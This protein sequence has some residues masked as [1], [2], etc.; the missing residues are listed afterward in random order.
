MTRRRLIPSVVSPA[1]D[2]LRAVLDR[3]TRTS[4]SGFVL[5]AL[6][7][8]AVPPGAL[9]NPQ[10]GT[11]VGGQAVISAPVPNQVLIQQQS[12]R[13]AIDWQSFSIGQG[14]ITRFQQPNAG[15][16]TLNRVTGG[17][18]SA[19]AG[20][21]EANGSI[22]LVNP[23]GIVFGQGAQV[24]VGGL[25]A[26][27]A[28]IPTS[29]FMAG[30]D[31]FSIPSPNPDAR[32]VNQ[33]T[34]NIRNQGLGALVAPGV[35]NQG[36]I[37]ARGG[38]IALGAAQTVTVDL[39]GDGLI[40]FDTGQPVQQAPLGP[41]GK[42][43][44]ALV[45]NS[46]TLSATGGT[47]IMSARAASDVVANV[48]NTTGVVEAL[49]VG[50]EG[51]AI[52]L[53]GGDTG[54]VRVDG[55]LDASGQDAGETGGSVTV[56][57]ERVVL[58]ADARVDASGQAGGGTA[59]IG[60]GWQGQGP[61]PTAQTTIVATGAQIDVSAKDRGDGGTAVVWADGNTRF[62]GTINARG[63]E[64]GGDGGQVEV[65]G[66]INLQF[67]GIVDAAAKRGRPGDL[68]LDPET[69]TVVEQVTGVDDGEVSDNLV[70]E[71]DSPGAN[72]QISANAIEA[73]AA[74]GTR[75]RLDA[76]GNITVDAVLDMVGGL[77]LTSSG[78]DITINQSVATDAFLDFSAEAGTITINASLSVG[79]ASS[80]NFA[81]LSAASFVL[82]DGVTVDSPNITVRGTQGDFVVGG[83]SG[84]L[85]TTALT[86]LVADSSLVLQA[87]D[88]T[89]VIGEAIAGDGS[90]FTGLFLNGLAGVTVDAA[91]TLTG[92]AATLSISSNG[93]I[94]VNAPLS[95]ASA[96]GN[97]SLTAGTFNGSNGDDPALLS[98]GG[99]LDAADIFLTAKSYSIT[100]DVNGETILLGQTGGDLI[101]GGADA[102]VTG[103]D[104][105]RLN[106]TTKLMIGGDFGAG[107]ITGN[108][109]I[110]DDLAFA[111]DALILASNDLVINA[112]ITSTSPGTAS[113]AYRLHLV[114]GND[115][116]LS[117]AG[118]VTGTYAVDPDGFFIAV[119]MFADGATNGEFD[120]EDGSGTLTID[121]L[122]ST[123]NAYLSLSAARYD[124][125][126][127]VDIATGVG[128]TV[129]KPDDVSTF[130]IGGADATISAADVMRFASATQVTFGSILASNGSDR[131]A[132]ETE[133]REA[134]TLTSATLIVAS[135]D[136][137]ID[138]GASFTATGVSVDESIATLRLGSANNTV[139]L[140][141]SGQLVNL[142][143]GG[144]V[145][146]SG[147]GNVSIDTAQDFSNL[148]GSGIDVQF[149]AGQSIFIN[150]AVDL[151]DG[152]YQF[153]A[154]APN[155]DVGGDGAGN[156]IL[157]APITRVGADGDL[158][159]S[160]ADYTV[161]A[162][163]DNAGGT[164]G[165]ANL[166]DPLTLG[167]LG[168][169]NAAELERF[170]TTGT[171][172]LGGIVFQDPAGDFLVAG[173]IVA[174][175]T[176]T[177]GTFAP[178][179]NAGAVDVV[180]NTNIVVD[181][182]EVVDF[183]NLTPGTLVR[184]LGV[185]TV[186]IGGTILA[187]NMDLVLHAD[188]G[189]TLVPGT[190]SVPGGLFVGGTV[191]AARVALAGYL[192]G[193]TGP[194]MASGE[195]S[196]VPS[197]DGATQE[198]YEPITD[199][200]LPPN[201]V[202]SP[203]SLQQLSGGVV[204]IGA[205]SLL[206]MVTGLLVVTEAL[207]LGNATLMTSL[208]DILVNADITDTGFVAPTGAYELE[209]RAG[210]NVTIAAG[211]TVTLDP[212]DNS[213]RN[214]GIFADADITGDGSTNNGAGAV[215]ILG[216]VLS[217][218][219]YVALS[220][221]GISV[222]TGGSVVGDTGIGIITSQP[223][224]AALVIG[225]SGNLLAADLARIGNG[226][227]TTTFGRIAPI[228]GTAT[229]NANVTINSS[230]AFAGP[231]V[232]AAAT[233]ITG[234]PGVNITADGNL[235]LD[236]PASFSGTAGIA[237]DGS[238][239]FTDTVAFLGTTTLSAGTTFAFQGAVTAT[240]QVVS[241]TA[242]GILSL[243]GSFGASQLTLESTGASVTVSGTVTVVTA[244]QVTAATT[245]SVAQVDSDNSVAF[246]T[247]GA[248]ALTGNVTAGSNLTI[249]GLTSG[250]AA[251]AV[252]Q[253]SGTT[254]TFGT[255]GDLSGGSVFINA[256]SLNFLG[257][258]ASSDELAASVN[259]TTSG[260]LTIAGGI[261]ASAITNAN[262][263]AGLVST[264]GSVN[265]GAVTLG[266]GALIGTGNGNVQVTGAISAA[267]G[268]D[269]TAAT[270]AVGVTGAL[271]AS[272]GA[273]TIQTAV[274]FNPAGT[275]TA[276]TNLSIASTSADLALFGLQAG[277]AIAITTN[278]AVQF[279]A[280][281]SAGQGI[282]VLGAGGSGAAASFSSIGTVTFG[283][284][285]DS[286]QS[287]V[288]ITANT[289]SISGGL[290]TADTEAFGITITALAGPALVGTIDASA[291]TRG[292][293]SV[294]V[295][296]TTTVDVGAINAG[297]GSITL[298]SPN[299]LTVSGRLD[300]G[301]S[302]TLTS[303]AAIALGGAVTAGGTGI[304]LTAGTGVTA[305]GNAALTTGAGDI[306]VDAGSGD[307]TLRAMTAD[308]NVTVRAD[309]T[310]ALGGS[311]AAGLSIA[312]GGS[313]TTVA[314]AVTQGAGIQAGFGTTGDGQ[315]STL[316]INA[317]SV[318]LD[319]TLAT[320]D[321]G[322][323]GITITTNPGA[324]AVG[325]IDAAA[326]TNTAFAVLL[327]ALGLTP[328]DIQVG[329]IAAG[330]GSVTLATSGAVDATGA[331]A[332][333][334]GIVIDAGTGITAAAGLTANSG[335]IDL[336]A[337][338]GAAQV[339]ALTAAG[340]VTI[341]ADGAIAL[342]GGVTAGQ[343]VALSGSSTTFSGAV[344]MASGL[345]LRFGTAN[346]T[347]VTA[348]SV[349][350]QSIALNG[351]ILTSDNQAGSIDLL[352][353]AGSVA[354]GSIAAGNAGPLLQITASAAGGSNS[355]SS[356]AISAGGGSVALS[357]PGLLTVGGSLLAGGDVTLTSSAAG[358]VAN[359]GITGGDITITAATGLDAL[360]GLDADAGDIAIDAGSGNAELGPVSASGGVQ[361]LAD[362]Q[363]RLND[364]LTAGLSVVLG[365]SSGG[366]AGAVIQAATATLQ[367]GTAGDATVSTLSVRGRSVALDGGI[368]TADD[369]LSTIDILAGLNS[370]SVG[371][372]TTLA[373]TT[374]GLVV[375]ISALGAEAE[376]TLGAI[377]LG[378]G[379]LVVSADGLV[380]GN[381]RLDAA[382]GIAVTSINDGI[383]L[384]GTVDAGGNAVTLDAETGVDAVA[385]VSGGD[386]TVDGGVGTVMLGPVT[387]LQALSVL[388]DGAIAL[389]GNVTAGF[390]V[391]LAGSGGTGATASVVQSAG[392]SLVVG[393][394]ASG[395]TTLRA[396]ASGALTFGGSVVIA[397]PQ[398]DEVVLDAGT[399]LSLNLDAGGVTA[400]AFL[401][402]L[403]AGTTATMGVMDLGAGSLD[404][405]AG[406]AVTTA[407]IDAGGVVQLVSASG[408]IVLD[409]ALTFGGPLALIDGGTG[410]VT[411]GGAVN[412]P[413]GGLVVLADGT[414][415]INANLDLALGLLVQGSTVDAMPV[416]V[417]SATDTQIRIGLT[418]DAQGT[419]FGIDAQSIILLGDIVLVDGDGGS[420]VVLTSATSILLNQGLDGAGLGGAGNQVA[421]DAAAE[422]QAARLVDVGS[423]SLLAGAGNAITF[424]AGITADGGVGLISD[425]DIVIDGPVTATAG[426]LLVDSLG[427]VVIT[428]AITVG[429]VVSIVGS[430]DI[431]LGGA[432]TAPTGLLVESTDGAVTLLGAAS[433]T[434]G[435]V[436]IEA[437]QNVILADAITARD[438]I[439][440]SG[441][442]GAEV[443]GLSGG[444]ITVDGGTEAASVSG[445]LVADTEVLLVADGAITIAADV[446]AGAGFSARGTA[447]PTASA[448]SVT[449]AAGTT[450]LFGTGGSGDLLIR[451]ADVTL[452]GTIASAG[453]AGSTTIASLNTLTIGAL[454]LTSISD[455]SGTSLVTL[456]TGAD[457]RATGALSLGV[458]DLD[459]AA[460]GAITL[461]GPVE[462]ANIDLDATGQLQ[463]GGPVVATGTL[464]LA[465]IADVMILA[466]APLSGNGIT[467]TSRSG[468][469]AMAAGATSGA[470]LSVRAAGNASLV[471]L[472]ANG[473]DVQVTAGGIALSGAVRSSAAVRLDSP[474]A[475]AI[476]ADVTA[477]TDVTVLGGDGPSTFAG[478]VSQAAGTTIRFGDDGV[479]DFIL[480]GT[481]VVLAGAAIAGGSSG[482][483]DLEALNALGIGALDMRTITDG[484]GGSLVRLVAG[485][486]FTASG[487]IQ[488]GIL[489]LNVTV[490]GAIVL[491]G[492]AQAAAIA[493]QGSAITVAGLTTSVGGLVLSSPGAIQLTGDVVARG[494][495][496]IAGNAAARVPAGSVSQAAGTRLT[497]G[498]G[499][500]GDSLA[501]TLFITAGL[502]NLSGVLAAGDDIAV[503]R[504][505]SASDL[506]LGAL[507]LSLVTDPGNGSL[508]DLST[509]G[510]FTA[511]G[512]LDVGALA[513]AVSAAGD[514]DLGGA[515]RAASV[516]LASDAD[517]V[518]AAMVTAPGGISIA[519]GGL[520]D[521]SAL[522]A[523]AGDISVTGAAITTRGAILGGQSL[524]FLSD[525]VIS[526]GAD[527]TAALDLTV[528]GAG[529]ATTFATAVNQSAG[530]V[531]RFATGGDGALILRGAGVSLAG[532]LA[533]AG[534]SGTVDVEATG[535][536]G[537]GGIDLGSI[538]DDTGASTLRL[539]AGGNLTASG[540]IDA[541]VLDLVLSVPGTILLS[542]PATANAIQLQ[543][544]AV[545]AAGLSATGGDVVVT[546]SGDIV[547]GAVDTPGN[548]Q[549][550]GASVDL[551]G[552]LTAGGSIR[553]TASNGT[554]AIGAD[555]TA[556]GDL[557]ITGPGGN[558]FASAVTQVAGS[559]I[560]FGGDLFVRG[561]TVTL[562]GAILSTGTAGGADIEGQAG[563]SVGSI[564]VSSILGGPGQL[565]LAAGGPV[566][567]SGALN[568]GALALVAS[569]ATAID[570]DG[571]VTAASLNLSSSGAIALAAVDSAG[572]VAIV[573]G[574]VDLGG[575]LTAG[576]SVVLQASNGTVAIGA[577]L[578]AGGDLDITGPGGNTFASAVTQVAGSTI[579]FGGDLFV[580]GG[581]VTLA[582]AI[583]STGTAGG[584]DI[585][586][587]AGLSVGSIDVSS[588]L[589][590]P[591]QLRLAAG[592]PVTASGALDAGALAL[593]AS[594]ATAIDLDGP[595]TAASLNLSSSGAIVL[596]AVDSAGDVAIVGGTVDLGGALTAGGSVVLQAS[597]G[598]VAIGADLTAGGDLDITGPGGNTFASA[599]TQ[600]AGSTI[601]FGGSLFVRG[602]T[603]T[604]AGAILSTG[605]AGGADIEAQ[606]GLSVGSIDVS[607]ILGGPGQLRLVA[608]GP[609]TASGALDAGALAL[610]ASSAT[611]IDLDGAVTAA[612]LNLS[613]SGA[614]ALA[615]VDSAGDVAI[616]GG[617][618]DLGG[619]L[620]AG[621]SVVLQA[622]NGTVAI[623]AEL[624]AGGDLDITGPSGN[625]FASAVTQ[626]AGSAIRFGGDL[627]VRGLAI[628]L[629]GQIVATASTGSV[630]IAAQGAVNLGSLDLSAMTDASGGGVLELNG[631]SLGVAGVLN[632]GALALDVAVAGTIVLNGPTTA[633]SIALSGSALTLGVLTATQGSIGL[634][635]V[636]TIALNG[637]VA[638]QGDV[639]IAGIG[640]APA[641]A[642]T[643][644]AGTTLH[645]G[646]GGAGDA[647]ASTLDIRADSVALAGAIVAADDVSVIRI[648]SGSDLTLGAIDVGAVTV[649]GNGSLIAL[650][651]A[652]AFTA[653]GAVDA[654]V[655]ALSIAAGQ[656]ITIAGPVAA[657]SLA[658]T[659]GADIVLGAALTAP[660]GITLDAGGLASTAGLSAANGDI[661]V[662]A[663]NI[664][665][666]GQATA[667]GAIGLYS[668]AAITLDASLTAGAD[669]ILAGRGATGTPAGTITQ[670]AGTTLAFG[671]RGSGDLRVV[672]STL[673]LAGALVALGATG[674]ISLSATGDLALGSLDARALG[675]GA[676]TGVFAVA[677][678]NLAVSGAV[679][680]G[681][682]SLLLG[683]NGTL[684]LGGRVTGGDIR[685]D[686][687]GPI[688]AAG[689]IEALGTVTIQALQEVR[690]ARV[691]AQGA[692]TVNAGQGDLAVSG[693]LVSLGD[694]VTVTAAGSLDFTGSADG[695]L[696][697]LEAGN[698]LRLVSGS[699]LT[700]GRVTLSAGASIA[701]GGEIDAT[702]IAVSAVTGVVTL[703]GTLSAG[704]SLD[705]AAATVLQ[706]AG[707]I[708]LLG[709][710]GS[711]A[712]AGLL[713]QGDT[714]ALNGTLR[715]VHDRVA[716]LQIIS[717]GSLDL[718]GADLTGVALG[719]DGGQESALVLRAGGPL[720]VS[721]DL[722]LGLAALDVLAGGDATLAGAVD[723]ARIRLSLGS[724]TLSTGALTA[725]GSI[726]V[727]GGTTLTLGPL[728][729][730]NADIDVSSAG[731]IS[732]ADLDAGGNVGIAGAVV[733]QTGTI[734][735]GAAGA[736][737]GATSTLS[738]SGGSVVLGDIVLA[739]ERSAVTLSADD[740]LALGAVAFSFAPGAVP[741]VTFAV[742]AGGT[743]DLNGTLDVAQVARLEIEAGGDL[744]INGRQTLAQGGRFFAG[745]TLTIAADLVVS[746]GLDPLA[747]LFA[748]NAGI[749]VDGSVTMVDGGAGPGTAILAF[750][751]L[752]GDLVV[753][754]D[755]LAGDART[756]VDLF[757]D[758]TIQVNGALTTATL[759]HGGFSYASASGDLA[760]AREGGGVLFGGIGSDAFVLG[761]GGSIVFG[762]GGGAIRIAA[763]DI[764]IN[765]A[766]TLAGAVAGLSLDAT[767]DL[768]LA[769][770]LD[771]VA[772][773]SN[774]T[775][776]LS[777][778]RALRATAISVGGAPLVM[779]AGTDLVLDGQ[780]TA[781]G[782]VSLRGDAIAIRTGVAAAGGLLV[783][784]AGARLVAGAG[785][786][787]D[788]AAL[789]R[790]A[791]T[792]SLVLGRSLNADGTF[793]TAA[794]VTVAG[795][796]DLAL[797]TRIVAT[798]RIAVD[799]SLSI[800]AVAPGSTFALRLESGGDI[801]LNGGISGALDG[802]AI[803]V[804]AAG[805]IGVA[806]LLDFSN[807]SGGDAARNRVSLL[808]GGDVV[809]TGTI[810][811]GT[812]GLIQADATLAL[813]TGVTGAADGVGTLRVEGAVV[814]TV[815]G[816]DGSVNLSGA[817]IQVPGLV[818]A[819]MV[820]ITSSG[821]LLVVGNGAEATLTGADIGN[822][823]GREVNIG[824]QVLA[825]LPGP[826]TQ[827]VQDLLVTGGVAIEAQ[828]RILRL[829][830]ARDV[831]VD[832]VLNLTGAVP[833]VILAAGRD[834]LVNGI[835]TTTSARLSLFADDGFT[836]ETFGASFQDE[837]GDVR[838]A[839]DISAGG[840]IALS[841]RQVRIGGRVN[842]L[843]RIGVVTSG[844]GLTT[845][846]GTAA[847]VDEASLAR[848]LAG[849]GVFIGQV[850]SAI[851]P[852]TTAF[853]TVTDDV[854]L[855]NQTVLIALQDIL[856]DAAL[857]DVG[858]T[859]GPGEYELSL[860][861]GR[862]IRISTTGSVTLAPTDGSARNL[863]LFADAAI[864]LP[865]GS[866][867]LP[868]R[869]GVGR[870]Q[871]DGA[872]T[873]QNGYV[874][875]SAA[876]F[877]I[878]ADVRGDAGVGVVSSRPELDALVLGGTG[879][880]IDAASIARIASPKVVSFGVMRPL[881]GAQVANF[882][883][884]VGGAVALGSATILYADR[885]LVIDGAVA[886]NGV[887][888]T[889]GIAQLLAFGRQSLTVNAGISAASGGGLVN[890]WSSGTIAINA[891]Q[892]FTNRTG[893]GDGVHIQAGGDI[894]V[895]ADIAFAGLLSIAADTTAGF[896]S[897]WIQP[898][899]G[900]GTLR[901]SA[902]IT[903]TGSL[904]LLQGADFVV[905]AGALAQAANIDM[906][907]SIGGLSVGGAA[908]ILSA[909]ELAQVRAT[910][911]VLGALRYESETFRGDSLDVVGGFALDPGTLSARLVATNDITV[912]ATS[913]ITGL[914]AAAE[915]VL[916]AGGDIRIQAALNAGVAQLSLLA[917]DGLT[918]IGPS[919][920]DGAGG[921]FIDADVTTQGL[922]ALSGAAIQVNATA[923]GVAGI[924]IV[925]SGLDMT[926]AAG[927]TVDPGA[928]VRLVTAG[929]VLLGQIT[930]MGSTIT[931]RDVAIAAATV[932]QA[933]TTILAARD[934]SVN[935]ALVSLASGAP[936]G[937]YDLLLLAGRTIEVGA[938]GSILLDPADG[939]ARN[940]GLFADAA[941]PGTGIGADG[942][943]SLVLAGAVRAAG[944]Y[945]SLSAADF[946]FTATATGD[947][948][949]GVITSRPGSDALSL[950]SGG[951]MDGGSAGFLRSPARISFGQIV[952]IG[953][954]AVSV[955]NLVVGP[956]SPLALSTALLDF[957]GDRVTVNAPLS[958][959][960]AAGTVRLSALDGELSIAGNV[961]TAGADLVLAASLGPILF[962]GTL[963]RTAGGDLLLTGDITFGAASARLAS[964]GGNVLF[965]GTTLAD[966]LVIDLG[967]GT[968]VTNA[969]GF[970][971][972]RSLTVIGTGGSADLQG[973]I[974]GVA[975][976]AAAMLV[977]RPGGANAAYL[978][979]GCPVVS[980]CVTP[981]EPPVDPVDELPRT[982]DP[983][984]RLTLP[985][986][987][988]PGQTPGE[989]SSI[990]DA[991]MS[992]TPPVVLPSKLDPKVEPD[993]RSSNLGDN[994]QW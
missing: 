107:T 627:F 314:T 826:G 132:D 649:P 700:G 973:I 18:L 144:T 514:I 231:T 972:A 482:S 543:A 305:T 263:T 814:G 215:Q 435:E 479:G 426:P 932:F 638:G 625:T 5:G 288:T 641:G 783:N 821:A 865:V 849:G 319:G 437:A 177:A 70:D 206:D 680:A 395:G 283:T 9:A 522:D 799:G 65:S 199:S 906:A 936:A 473:G 504:L 987:T 567:A 921:L 525:G 707:S 204:S 445:P 705:V 591:G 377:V 469:V 851:G 228:G 409:G 163:V 61:T 95:V 478:A 769:S 788:A 726:A 721:G 734:R 191:Q 135:G 801:A 102:T 109:V 254:L 265:L 391:T 630:D 681:S 260:A 993:F 6:M 46:G 346:D 41:D 84:A 421:F 310:I 555:L 620:T 615:A 982:Y 166:T 690:L 441:A 136:L 68:L 876:A 334:A 1:S 538:S 759:T 492:P 256:A 706:D 897:G 949:V 190:A 842:A 30:R 568:A 457:L 150:A 691:Q 382:Q 612:S 158:F 825:G 266:A 53:S 153:I 792:S 306:L 695:A 239:T 898:A 953:G 415:A 626:V 134:L 500:L 489:D 130:I 350:A 176:G 839:G 129:S 646:L 928:F 253:A 547:L 639:V 832:G 546:S 873:A 617:T 616:V 119:A 674:S 744:N 371:S 764:T 243:G 98:I 51:G 230:V 698:A 257:G 935:A 311:V 572:D 423:A 486:G 816:V 545:T 211:V 282:T 100:A 99:T 959:L 624:T 916:A 366:D 599:V 862:N 834:V 38:T 189:N 410:N 836:A 432:I 947:A 817:R 576:G 519:A 654:G 751:A 351:S 393:A 717:S 745:G 284:P 466:T 748:A 628:D 320:L 920:A 170:T 869:D 703:S 815:A 944:G 186:S 74:G 315:A 343:S 380:Q 151:G 714:I 97:L 246:F 648:A 407:A 957:T 929:R 632:A 48:I 660:G 753:N 419:A 281:V 592:G 137:L 554:V 731:S 459:V 19:I 372:L 326:V 88:G 451:G 613:S 332:G 903:G 544:A 125:N 668:A 456:S 184:F 355:L 584:A 603:V 293:F 574:T 644:A 870:L 829:L 692:I 724:G 295:S 302:V 201:P 673:S 43:V 39:N 820:N 24:D 597:N 403:T 561:G 966:D 195:V 549:I 269:L 937:F 663:G 828:A 621:G 438:G 962:D 741:A 12:D 757:A 537:L 430:G 688:T 290:N 810:L 610:V 552:V 833:D 378:N 287:S 730:R 462:A 502:V 977:D 406:L 946:L 114:A 221:A 180:S 128:L 844:L 785:G 369:Q 581:T 349:L 911:L 868:T 291:V 875:L 83:D 672:G 273:V 361:V 780:V 218:G 773:D 454:D 827:R 214:I 484:G 758:G 938:G 917:D 154:D 448:A 950:G 344:T 611:A 91:I 392:T 511:S 328:V 729:S 585:E 64:N 882:D 904:L 341:A 775:V 983:T 400:S 339:A 274:D 508:I 739:D 90:T 528:A 934:I 225:P 497:F 425:A 73:A 779:Q 224:T 722:A 856:V 317:G 593:V 536:L 111:V 975:G 249:R 210:G 219:G 858:T 222:P 609:V 370:V 746:R 279:L 671:A 21:I 251:G 796:V 881:G 515:I 712:A 101:I 843:G 558:T 327:Q 241:A 20:Q 275:I 34:I 258:L 205:S 551:Q 652:G 709:S 358:V 795:A 337:G 417:T 89:L 701:L 187:P 276:G 823:S 940:L 941:V 605:T 669:I 583:L 145:I 774:A 49:T 494:D 217:S 411:I 573:G 575:A 167:A 665:L 675:P 755:V 139:T 356:G 80:F 77:A 490:P 618:V 44:D 481:D 859:A 939:S 931:A 657:G 40:S 203:A 571:V 357:A 961:T 375:T 461:D 918:G 553:L 353:S 686:V 908:G 853:V 958:I 719:T 850:Q 942:L 193:I 131:A 818:T 60:G 879:A 541:G 386:V 252:S 262:F 794:E 563:L 196:V 81:Q 118:S 765:G 236:G 923:T 666:G 634:A 348:L 169:L 812:G 418:G 3:C 235:T 676:G 890:L 85:S 62:G 475:I 878:T 735:F 63:G 427:G 556:G 117:A 237:V 216:S 807:R 47:V 503:L 518:L 883:T 786:T 399:A 86:Q 270:G 66:K 510:A 723:A 178:A 637:D 727:T 905:D 250:S 115:L 715:V 954:A 175:T 580:R 104:I 470:G 623:G 733:R 381:G 992:I 298:D 449:Q 893:A 322:A 493:L 885:T 57:G 408:G 312:L 565:R 443:S 647:A 168:I 529:G 752:G 682:Q 606:A 831:T 26:T 595:V 523:S 781:A 867:A 347:L 912:S 813:A 895:N 307:A 498:G 379:S 569:S 713:I 830:A 442:L 143:N 324:L 172:S 329:A 811:F 45:Q 325:T 458:L 87:A 963:I 268:V 857:V 164:I 864:D 323:G 619:A 453:S 766:V 884:R 738:V 286:L 777:A 658:L 974:N 600:V 336:D 292:G 103:A 582:G 32:V 376:V 8:L 789:G 710:A 685:F 183:G 162:A 589:G 985:V 872:V 413:V 978:F 14:E 539:A 732:L 991:L 679:L 990:V 229:T 360:G 133:V 683:S 750:H 984:T 909:I 513:L 483:A 31:S 960:A 629:A 540:A 577:D 768:T 530:T 285:G 364:A 970:I 702:A 480:R 697:A 699:S 141:N 772:L 532:L 342:G 390:G 601:R 542:G 434:A 330:L 728:V 414:V 447:G 436:S 37:A 507:D 598:T 146:V 655:L 806:G 743:L 888:T 374:T 819:S 333:A 59:L 304:A 10:G 255:S 450:I 72:F 156:I 841:G 633:A 645:F 352:A 16:V 720:T 822:I 33:G 27:T 396:T 656:G 559:T 548:A 967:N 405:S 887:S 534:T 58:G 919:L 126:A 892:D 588:I 148:V 677:L 711:G 331:I 55:T 622:S 424:N 365:G 440:V 491:A 7:A 155:S 28:D 517:I 737:D 240:G 463:L 394:A 886:A 809:V 880:T 208:T 444:S 704:T 420:S 412:A 805:A 464:A 800:G 226:T 516:D 861:A 280:N 4:T 185:D 106:A 635:A 684:T 512:A 952:P 76:T 35:E 736:G 718:A 388:T 659:A 373:T 367:F 11:V 901:L 922:L 471:A 860:I 770:A 112:A 52:I 784:A 149:L 980:G 431:R 533:S 631:N 693:S 640:T 92:T 767:R 242:G 75:V 67:I 520:A 397:D 124:V 212:A 763:T 477:A 608:G 802:G 71:T 578:T 267:A 899:D 179:L 142:P 761:S 123:T 900:V 227:A 296:A 271:T 587:Q 147:G 25:V 108:I 122:I 570:L 476:N 933:T 359:A 965:G 871:V 181:I 667:G 321:T 896:V 708:I 42:P 756:S 824:V 527:A 259:I 316:V 798:D 389:T 433:A 161:T 335:G 499:G 220:G 804:W 194:V 23:N 602:G 340:D 79:T 13:A 910:N 198:I 152:R 988:G 140:A 560:R 562:A 506:T 416:A 837:V 747:A 300:A 94:A 845:L 338:S 925:G 127:D 913:P 863:G 174:F 854:T 678:G 261:A 383:S 689:A 930:T 943:G 363:I 192:I 116:T 725:R 487:A 422:F 248:I 485:T 847:T 846:G 105:A 29:D 165:V 289:V 36:V 754:G 636:G 15:S 662:L 642:V 566:T 278:G 835:L 455:T 213:A 233:L 955:A 586:G 762:A 951:V 526:F 234:G 209:L 535:D 120:T 550:E 452:A 446:T 56:T 874:A 182:G 428:Q 223:A 604:L 661:L 840:D 17:D 96:T 969:A 82:A 173:N 803:D 793:S 760:F 889:A 653:T 716:V 495:V 596:A 69:I 808:A 924:G 907:G 465:A 159:F 776:V 787:I 299:N 614:I 22:F 866:V 976:P 138:A 110:N 468:S 915:L 157:A 650:Q 197:Q 460:P 501:S 894:A 687:A 439:L 264:G 838:V 670:A 113:T 926:V 398:A 472:T 852:R 188:A 368:T 207:S 429:S 160:A 318:D 301:G 790:L 387:A 914:T 121:G 93:G 496:T 877:G 531:L 664:L 467:V 994:D 54:T 308:G 474:G 505:V 564:D 981:P 971:I 956:M 202:I 694:G 979:N 272:A 782:L 244:F 294:S 78:G 200:D 524:S 362:G 238:L 855:A 309:G 643:Q 247:P 590:G 2:R 594:S 401:V 848:V 989:V 927:G 891:A 740:G 607:S 354:I 402:T 171:L 297:A 404:L 742:R 948:G 791:G 245:I 945:L 749:V 778:G 968:A 797:Q 488:A 277:G 986:G 345:E 509:G 964:L 232:V 579:R 902:A 557:N 696:V 651:T 303:D 313:S 385:S 521:V 384:L 771:L 50:T